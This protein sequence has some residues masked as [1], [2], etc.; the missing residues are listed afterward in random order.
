MIFFLRE[1]KKEKVGGH[2]QISFRSFKN[3]SVDEYEKVLGKVTFPNYEKYNIKKA[4]NDFLFRKL[5]K[6]VNNISPLKAM[7]IKNT[8]TEWFDREIAEKLS[9][10]DKLFKKF[11]SSR[12]NIDWEIY[13]EARNDIQRTIKEKKKQYLEE[14]L[15]ENIAKPK[16]LWQTLKQLGL[17]NKKNSPSNTCLKKII[18]CYSTHCQ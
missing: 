18:I 2:K 16:E 11:K 17:P 15:S 9:I 10:R 1:I 8:S 14:K 6:V 5:I 13:K 4:Y 7:R 3:Y 12:L